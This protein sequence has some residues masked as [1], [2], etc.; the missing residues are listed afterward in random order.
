MKYNV[1]QVFYLVGTE[2][3]KVIPFR[4]IEEITRTTLAGQEKTYI[5]ELPDEKRTQIEVSKL[6]GEIFRN[7]ETLSTHMIE[8]AKK[9]I[10]KMIDDADKLASISFELKNTQLLK[11]DTLQT[12]EGIASKTRKNVTGFEVLDK[13]DI[14]HKNNS[15]QESEKSDIV[16]VDIGNG[17]VAN[18][19]IK[20]LEKVSQI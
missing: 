6:K 15:V 7:L 12:Q 20:D 18:M 16:K 14:E 11:E 9:A 1:G 13:S 17:V 2:T 3:A 5:A 10:S 4:I 19:N 8:N